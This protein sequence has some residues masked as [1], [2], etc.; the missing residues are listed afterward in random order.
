MD[1]SAP[2]PRRR[3]RYADYAADRALADVPESNGHTREAARS[4][5]I[6]NGGSAAAV[7]AFVGTGKAAGLDLVVPWVA[8]GAGLI[9]GVGA[10]FFQALSLGEWIKH[11]DEILRW[12]LDTSLPEGSETPKV[13]KTRKFARLWKYIAHGLLALSL[14]AFGIGVWSGR[15]TFDGGVV[16]DASQKA[17]LSDDAPA[18]IQ[19]TEMVSPA[20]N[21][22]R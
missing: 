16:R 8:F 13:T 19:P 5:L 3:S 6:L 17:L 20:N 2:G 4:L 15:D 12:K 10:L 1:S 22:N 9:L 18:R 21:Q 11:W 7:L 14:L